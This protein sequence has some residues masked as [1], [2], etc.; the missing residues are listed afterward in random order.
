[1]EVDYEVD[2]DFDLGKIFGLDLNE[3]GAKGFELLKEYAKT[4]EG[5]GI[6]SLLVGIIL[7]N[8]K[9]KLQIDFYSLYGGSREKLQKGEPGDFQSIGGV[10]FKGFIPQEWIDGIEDYL[11]GFAREGLPGVGALADP[12]FG[13]VY[14]YD[15]LMI[16]GLTILFGSS[17]LS[18]IEG[19]RSVK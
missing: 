15:V 11:R 5:I 10:W 13:K 17:A 4:R 6:S 14:V 19:F 9:F 7:K 18:F 12:D 3:L 1:M 16:L 2:A 8:L